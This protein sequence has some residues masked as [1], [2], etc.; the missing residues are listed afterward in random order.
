MFS[1]RRHNIL[2]SVR[3][4]T[5]LLIELQQLFYNVCRFTRLSVC[6][7]LWYAFLLRSMSV[8][9]TKNAPTYVNIS[10]SYRSGHTA[11]LPRGTP[12]Q[13]ITTKLMQRFC[14]GH[15]LSTT[16][17]L[18]FWHFKKAIDNVWFSWNAVSSIAVARLLN[19]RNNKLGYSGVSLS[20]KQP[21]KTDF[22]AALMTMVSLIIFLFVFPTPKISS[23]YMCTTVRPSNIWL[24]VHSKISG[25]EAIP[26]GN[27]RQWYPS[28]G[29]EKAQIQD[30]SSN[31]TWWK[32]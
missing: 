9:G 31:A 17:V 12:F 16:S 25:I 11:P 18:R 20:W 19:S 21:K 14:I 27:R 1:I 30:C 4:L 6:V 10:Q 26:K 23:M 29:V 5:W 7:F 24:I 3:W 2:F 8:T 22:S 32:L 13:G 28:K 15:V